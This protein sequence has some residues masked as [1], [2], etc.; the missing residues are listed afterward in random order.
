MTECMRDGFVEGMVLDG[1]FECVSP[2]NHGSFGM[3]F[4]AKDLAK[5]D[6]VA[7][8][9]LTKSTVSSFE[10]ASVENDYLLELGC[11]N[12]LGDH[13]NIVN[14]V[15]AFETPS[16][17]YLVMEYCSMGDLYEAIRLGR[18]PLK[19]E[20]V[21]DFMLQLV[22]AVEHMHSR[23]LFHR[24]IKPEN[25]FLTQ[26]GSMKLGD[27]GLSTT[28]TWTMEASVGS[29]RYMAP[30]QY[31]PQDTGYAPAQADVWAIGICLLNILFSRN[32]FVTPSESD[33]LFSDFACDKQSLFDVFPNMS[34]DT[35]EVIVHAMAID[36]KKR[37][38]DAVRDSLLRVVSFTTDDEVIDDFCT[39]EREVVPASANRQ[40][41]R[42]PS[43]QSPPIENSGAFPWAKA[44]HMSPPQ[45]HRQLSTIADTE[46]YPDEMFPPMD[47]DVHSWY[48]NSAQTPSLTSNLDSI[49][50]SAFSG[51]TKSLNLRMPAPRNP[52]KATLTALSESVPIPTKPIPAMASVFGKSDDMFSKS[53]SDLWDEDEEEQME[54]SRT[55]NRMNWSQESLDNDVMIGRKGISELDGSSATNRSLPLESAN[56]S[57]DSVND[58]GFE[59]VSPEVPRLSNHSPESKRSILDKWAMLGNRRRAATQ[60]REDTKTQSPRKR[61][62]S[63]LWRRGQAVKSPSPPPPPP[64]YQDSDSMNH[65]TGMGN[66]QNFQ[67]NNNTRIKGV[68]IMGLGSSFWDRKDIVTSTITSVPLGGNTNSKVNKVVGFGGSKFNGAFQQQKDTHNAHGGVR[69]RDWRRENSPHY[70]RYGRSGP[71]G[72]DGSIDDG[73]GGDLEWVGGR[74]DD[75]HL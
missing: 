65:G 14:L 17:M 2:L 46:L 42:T 25:I 44:L 70:Y 64:V 43:I 62:N 22:G 35:F 34:Q 7:I 69:V 19:T 1:R 27:F 52:P 6:L 21:R 28:E 29:D 8:K 23:G 38:L 48:S 20:H 12:R 49:V 45:T 3:V 41:L 13:P 24:D 11:H 33:L 55:L 5:H 71:A 37:S 53:W 36:P 30:E 67:S 40:P 61:G 58:N 68:G 63:A 47:K 16:H 9:C 10:G 39:E 75:L 26:D 54:G 59:R 18:G 73:D 15:D 31:D 57:T 4:L 50:D 51:S 72:F 66:L 56:K 60:E 32:P 74:W